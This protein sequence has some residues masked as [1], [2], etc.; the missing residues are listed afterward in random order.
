MHTTEPSQYA[1][2]FPSL[3]PFMMG[4]YGLYERYWEVAQVWVD[5]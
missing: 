1:L 5:G 3:V 2:H 4:V